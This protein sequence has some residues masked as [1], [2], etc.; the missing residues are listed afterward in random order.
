MLKTYKIILTVLLGILLPA[1]QFFSQNI[2]P[3]KEILIADSSVQI[4]IKGTATLENQTANI[5][6][7]GCKDASSVWINSSDEY[8]ILNQRFYTN[9]VSLPSEI[10]SMRDV[11]LALL[12]QNITLIYVLGSDVDELDGRVKS[13]LNENIF[14]H[15]RSRIFGFKPSHSSDKNT[16]RC[17]NH[18]F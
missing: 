1:A 3:I 14:N 9:E 2:L 12:G 10:T 4:T 5:A 7:P 8:K 16:E 11:L 15:R 18:R 6:L 17:Q 13:V